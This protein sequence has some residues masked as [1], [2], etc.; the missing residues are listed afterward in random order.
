MAKRRGISKRRRTRKLITNKHRTRYHQGRKRTR[1]YRMRGGRRRVSRNRLFGGADAADAAD[2]AK[3]AL[4]SVKYTTLVDL[5]QD[6]EG[7]PHYGAIT[8]FKLLEVKSKSVSSIGELLS[9][10]CEDAESISIIHG[11]R[12]GK[13]LAAMGTN[14]KPTSMSSIFQEFNNAGKVNDTD[15]EAFFEQWKAWIVDEHIKANHTSFGGMDMAQRVEEISG[16]NGIAY[17]LYKNGDKEIPMSKDNCDIKNNTELI[18][19]H[20][21]PINDSSDDEPEGA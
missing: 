3:T 10:L 20:L 14:I 6:F 5:C 16:G 15:K 13:A 11:K 7:A 4:N 19:W 8:T 9:K 1:A 18:D 21:L 2:A 17:W 12:R